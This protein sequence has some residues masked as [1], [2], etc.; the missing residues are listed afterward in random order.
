[1]NQAAPTLRLWR[2]LGL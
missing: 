2:D 1:M